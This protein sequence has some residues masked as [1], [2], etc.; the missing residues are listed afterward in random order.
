[1]S[2]GIAAFPADGTTPDGLLRSADAALY[3]AK[4]SGRNTFRVF[5]TSLGARQQARATVRHDLQA[6]LEAED[7]RLAYQPICE[8]PGRRVRGL[9]ALLRWEHPERGPVPPREFVPVAEATGL[10]GPLGRWVLRTACAE[11]AAWPEP[12][13][14]SVN[15]SPLQVRQPGLVAFVASILAE[16]GLEPRRLDLEV[17]EGVLLDESA[18]VLHTLRGLKELGVRIT[19]DDFGTAHAGLAWL[20]RFGFDRIKLGRGMV[21]GVCDD[22]GTQAVVQAVLSLAERLRIEVVAEGVETE[23]DLDALQ[24]AG[25]RLAQGFLVGHPTV[26]G[27]PA[28]AAGRQAAPAIAW[29]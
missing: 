11:A 10:I 12:W 7:F 5:D 13:E 26:G 21:A 9:E 22:E 28:W 18:T 2:I 17:T 8:L 24:R 29:W 6:A 1:M 25:C 23:R 15:L 27:G 19:L 16:T 4:Q 20:R 3:E 14:L